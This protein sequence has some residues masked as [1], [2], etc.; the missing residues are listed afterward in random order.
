MLDADF[1]VSRTFLRRTLGLFEAEDVAIVQTPQHFF[2][3]DPIQSSLLCAKV[4][5]DEQRFFFNYL[6]EAKDAWGAAFC[7]GTSAVLRVRHCWRSA[8]WRPR[9]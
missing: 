1:A 3:A 4:W 2:N 5:P 9:P 6:M 7:C 8:A